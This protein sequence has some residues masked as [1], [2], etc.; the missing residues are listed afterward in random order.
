MAPN[1]RSNIH[2]DAYMTDTYTVGGPL[3]DGA[4]PSTLF[5]RE[6]GSITFDSQGRIVSICVGLDRPVLALLDPH[7]LQT[8]A[9]MPLPIRNVT[10]GSNPFTDFSGGGYF[11][12]DDQDRAVLPTNDRHLLVVGETPAPGF[13]V[14]RDYDLSGAVPSGDAIESALPDWSGRFWFVTRQG[15]VGT[16]DRAS[17]AVRT[18]QLP[19]EGISNSFAVDETGGVFVVSDKALYRFDAGSG[20]EPKVTWGAVYPNSGIHKPGQSDAG[21]GT[22]PTL[23][24]K[25]WVAITDNADPMDVVVYDRSASLDSV[26]QASKKRKGK[27]KRKRARRRNQAKQRLVCS[28]PVFRQGA[29]ST[30]QSLIGTDS[31]IVAENNYGYSGIAATM[32]GGVTEPGLT[33]VDVVSSSSK[34]KTKKK[35]RKRRKRKGRGA[36]VVSYSCRTAWTSDER[37]PSVVPK[38]SLANGLV[39]TYTKPPRS[40]SVD[41][42]YL[43]ALDFRSGRTVYRRLAGTGFGFNNNYAPVTLGPDG[44]AYVGVLGGL[45]EFP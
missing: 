17:G 35:T 1:G 9:A 44:T 30:D 26:K 32:N 2:D 34:A 45:V 41:A 42:W 31:S 24:G 39:Y 37:A 21:S 27:K 20:G 16:V 18:L 15:M 28:E 5:L 13:Q 19:G 3:G 38:L 8:L 6:C 33:R 4:E 10:S 12:L 14:S 29:S 11:Y 23:M 25:D 36:P 22:T 43:T 7:T 40:D